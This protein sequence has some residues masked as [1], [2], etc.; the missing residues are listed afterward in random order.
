MSID[1]N[2]RL[3]SIDISNKS[4]SNSQ[5]KS[6]RFWKKSITIDN[7]PLQSTAI[8]SPLEPLF[9]DDKKN[10]GNFVFFFFLAKQLLGLKIVSNFS[11]LSDFVLS[12]VESNINFRAITLGCDK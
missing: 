8:D 12:S 3:L 6:Y 1:I 2:R 4:L 5:E 11:P 10:T 7:N 9:Y